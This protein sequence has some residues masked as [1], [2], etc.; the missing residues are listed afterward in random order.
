MTNY[1]WLTNADHVNTSLTLA[2][3]FAK[4]LFLAEPMKSPT[5]SAV[6]LQSCDNILDSFSHTLHVLRV[7][8][9]GRVFTLFPWLTQ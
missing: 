7:F 4:L 1:K 2:H 3:P 9:L 8:K 5:R 6:G